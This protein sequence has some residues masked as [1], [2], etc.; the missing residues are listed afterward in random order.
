ME[1]A[2]PSAAGTTLAPVRSEER[3]ESLDVVRGF[4]LFGIFLMNVEWFNRA[5][6][7]M[8]L[9]L[10]LG[11]GGADWWASRLVFVLVQGKF[12]TIFALL[13]GMGFAV[14]LLRAEQAGRS[15]LRPYLRRIAA[16]AL[17]GAAHH[18]LVWGGDIL[19]GYALTALSL[20]ILL[21]G[22]WKYIL[23][24]LVPLVGLGFIPKLDP[25]WAV[26]GGLAATGVAALYLRGERRLRFRGRSMLAFSSV[27]LALG[28]LSALAAGVL[29][30]LPQ[31]PKEPRLPVTIAAAA[32]LAVAILSDR[33]HDPVEARPRRLGLTLYLLPCLLVTAFGAAMLLPPPA[34]RAPLRNDSRSAEADRR[35]TQEAERATRI[36]KLQDKMQ[37]EARVHSRGR[38]LEA[39]R[40]RAREFAERAPNDA[41]SAIIMAGM[42]LLGTW[43]VR[44]GVMARSADHLPLFRRLAWI[45]IPL[46]VGLT[47][48]GAAICS[49]HTPGNQRDG[50]QLANG[51]M[52]AGSLPASL[53]YVSLV[54]LAL[55]GG[56]WVSR[57]RILA[58]AG[59]MAL[60]NY[61]L[62]SA[63]SAVVFFGYGFGHWGLGRAGQVLYVALVFTLQVAFSH[64]WLGWFRYGPMEWLWRAVTYWTIPPM[65]RDP[66]SGGGTRRPAGQA[67]P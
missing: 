59:R 53:G 62:Q 9:G 1:S 54:V 22:N 27:L 11:L 29:W 55:H 18:I 67:V 46:G 51:L 28:V 4:A 20:L 10:P 15:F 21:Y 7:E 43:F 3:I 64:L 19:F 44:S 47:V 30:A 23:A 33:F 12:W 60:T 14:M 50:W 66:A 65:R 36:R 17:F 49:S 32:L 45:G 26:A 8:A 48:A 31:G 56:P 25:L 52:A 16:L 57:I 61:L 38:Y 40:F 41:A 35:A 39:V 42:F 34:A 6:N 37:E 5:M 2:Q 58:P 13:F 63:V 24:A